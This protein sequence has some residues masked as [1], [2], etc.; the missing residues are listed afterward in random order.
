MCELTYRVSKGAKLLDQLN[1]D[2]YRKID[3]EALNMGTFDC[4]VLGQ[5]YCPFGSEACEMIGLDYSED[6]DR[7]YGFNTGRSSRL[8]CSHEM[9]LLT[10]A[11]LYEINQRLENQ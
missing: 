6:E 4:C 1:P 7:D 2:W 5:L 11:W 9:K 3:R 10:D 8:A